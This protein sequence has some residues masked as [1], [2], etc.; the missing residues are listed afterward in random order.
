MVATRKQSTWLRLDSISLR[1]SL[2]SYLRSLRLNGDLGD[3]SQEWAL[4]RCEHYVGRSTTSSE[5]YYSGSTSRADHAHLQN[6]EVMS[7]LSASD[8]TRVSQ[9]VSS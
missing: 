9:D 3:Y 1:K 4:S 7:I 8:V 2:A 6:D 5:T